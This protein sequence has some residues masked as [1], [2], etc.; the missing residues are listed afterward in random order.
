MAEPRDQRERPLVSVVVPT[1]GRSET[2]LREAVDSVRAQTYDNVELL[3]VD[4]SPGEVSA[5]LE[6]GDLAGFARITGRDHRGAGDARNTG[7][8]RAEGRYLAFLDDDDTWHPEKLARQVARLEGSEEV[9]VVYTALEYIR[10]GDGRRLNTS[11]A[12]TT[13]DVTRDLLEGA[14]LGTFST[15]LVDAS[16]VPR[17]GLVDPRFP[18]FEDREWCLRLSRHCRFASVSDPLVRYRRGDHDQLTDGF[19]ELRD[20][21]LPL[22]ER[23]HRPLAA[24]YGPDCERRFRAALRRSCALAAMSSGEYGEARRYALAALRFAPTDRQAWAYLAAAAGGPYTYRPLRAARR[25][26]APRL[27]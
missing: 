18:V 26:L 3:I 9:G 21:V 1:Y 11:A 5:S 15:L 16:L 20:T 10:D 24:A 19:R 25:W 7:I 12:A 4:D 27:G 17:A 22:F 2:H 13:G 8:W 6:A 14:N 23:K